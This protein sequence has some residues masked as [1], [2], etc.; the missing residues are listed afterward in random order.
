MESVFMDK[1]AIPGDGELKEKL[2]P[3]FTLWQSLKKYISDHV[4]LPAE[5]WNFPGKNYGWSF[6]M[7]SKKRNIIYFLPRQGFFMVAFVF[8]P[9]A[10]EKVMESQVNEDIKNDLRNATVY[11]EGRG[12]RIDVKDDKI[13]KE[14]FTLLEIK[15]LN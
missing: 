8:G 3:T 4:P 10:F 6:R 15:L 9:K 13:F 1:S 12:V 2:G 7:K 14:I 11:A 5:E